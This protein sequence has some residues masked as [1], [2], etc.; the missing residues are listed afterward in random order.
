[1]CLSES[2]NVLLKRAFGQVSLIRV[3]N[4]LLPNRSTK[5]VVFSA[6]IFVLSVN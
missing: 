3:N 4:N 5:K 6:L 1:M 2:V